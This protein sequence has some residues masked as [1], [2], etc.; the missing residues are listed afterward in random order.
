MAYAHTNIEVKPVFG[1][2]FVPTQTVIAEADPEEIEEIEAR[3]P[4]L[5][6]AA[7]RKL[8]DLAT[9]LDTTISR[10]S[11][12]ADTASAPGLGPTGL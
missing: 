8:L 9:R 10:L 6:P 12:P 5:K 7:A 1:V 11:P 3:P 2:D 4:G